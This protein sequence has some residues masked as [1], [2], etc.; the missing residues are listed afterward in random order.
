MLLTPKK[1]VPTENVAKQTLKQNTTQLPGQGL[2]V[3]EGGEAER[4]G[5]QARRNSS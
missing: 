1:T 5:R 4:V 3:A 2:S